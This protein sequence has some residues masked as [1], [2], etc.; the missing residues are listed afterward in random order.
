MVE[1]YIAARVFTEALRRI[2]RDPTRARLRK[3]IEGQDDL[4]IGGF[5]VHFVED[6]VAS[7]L[8]ES[9][10]IDSQGRVRE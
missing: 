9:G 7:R 8:V 10:L 1:G 2:S 6:R 3:A 4:N 5:R